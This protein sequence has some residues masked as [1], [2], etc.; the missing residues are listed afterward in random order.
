M[1]TRTCSQH[2][3]IIL[4]PEVPTCRQSLPNHVL[5]CLTLLHTIFHTNVSTS[6]NCNIITLRLRC[7]KDGG[8]KYIRLCLRTLHEC[9][10]KHV[11][12]FMRGSL[13]TSAHADSRS[14]L[15]T[16]CCIDNKPQFFPHQ[17]YR[18]LHHERR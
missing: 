8:L 15:A 12:P 11:Y 3:W 14:F 10:V 18:L 16:I 13:L 6:L 2:D 9:P 17:S 7:I 5:D 4:P 1:F